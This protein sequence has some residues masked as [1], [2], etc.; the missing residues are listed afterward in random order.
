MTGPNINSTK[1]SKSRD[2]WHVPLFPLG[3]TIHYYFHEVSCHRV[4]DIVNNTV[5]QNKQNFGCCSAGAGTTCA[6]LATREVK[7]ALSLT[8]F[9]STSKYL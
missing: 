9:Y 7:V 2:M 5:L 8:T 3:P 1:N 6:K 4:F